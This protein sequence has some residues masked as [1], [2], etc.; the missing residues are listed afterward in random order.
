MPKFPK[1]PYPEHPLV[2]WSRI[3]YEGNERYVIYHCE[4]C[5]TEMRRRPSSLAD[6][7]RKG[8]FLGRCAND[9][10]AHSCRQPLPDAEG[11]NYD[12]WKWQEV[13]R[14]AH[15]HRRK[16]VQVTCS[17]C[18]QERWVAPSAVRR[19]VNSGA[20]CGMCR[21]CR[22]QR[23]DHPSGGRH[24]SKYGYVTVYRKA[25]APE[26]LALFEALLTPG[27][28]HVF[29]HRLVMSKVLGRPIKKKEV[30]HHRNGVRDDNR[31][32]NLQL[33]KSRRQ[34]HPGHGDYYH[35]V[36]WLKGEV[37]A[38]KADLKQALMLILSSPQTQST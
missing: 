12:I 17:K 9:R 14:N 2:D 11:V 13:P 37:S 34:H 38:L 6:R 22:M 23:Y 15:C 1:T 26:D 19:Q 18:H 4:I 21:A 3:V 30:V 5:K 24:T 32:E 20:W 33:F 29:E 25:I 10:G 35:E 28:N 36:E 8:T 16:V 31:P 27:R 7:I